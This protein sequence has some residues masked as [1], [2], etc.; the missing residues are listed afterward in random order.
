MPLIS[1]SMNLTGQTA[2]I[3]PTNQPLKFIANRL[4]ICNDCINLSTITYFPSFYT[5]G[6]EKA[7]KIIVYYNLNNAILPSY[8]VETCCLDNKDANEL[9][10][11]ILF[12][13]FFHNSGSRYCS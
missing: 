5:H 2:I 1:F 11:K 7:Q 3:A 9:W 13:R 6:E 10:V 4:D 8:F 12:V